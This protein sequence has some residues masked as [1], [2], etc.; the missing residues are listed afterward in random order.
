MP[1]SVVV[2]DDHAVVRQGIASLLKDSDVE[3]VGEADGAKDAVAK[4][5][6]LQPDAVLMDV[7]MGANGGLEA[8]EELRKHDTKT[9]VIM[10]SSYD[11]PTYV[12]RSVALGANEYVLKDSSR[13]ELLDTIHRVVR[14]D[15]PS[16]D[17]LFGQI[18]D[19]MSRKR[20][21]D[22]DLPLTVREVQVLRHIALG[23]SNREIG[24]SL[25][26]SVETVK[27]HVQNI[28]RKID[29]TDRTQAAVW[30]VRKKLV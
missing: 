12:A 23:L 25:G 27:E 8:L 29:A 3:L 18:Q 30:A 19:L 4:I 10:L 6:K 15:E 14:G 17:R 11:N 2:A 1:I 26:I 24:L 21:P 7:R 13:E 20:E 9:R 5:L 16:V 22:D 28:L